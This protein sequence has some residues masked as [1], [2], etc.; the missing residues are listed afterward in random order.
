MHT[1]II[2]TYPTVVM[3]IKAHQ[4]PSK[5][6][7]RNPLGN[8]SVFIHVSYNRNRSMHHSWVQL[9]CLKHLKKKIEFEP[10]IWTKI[11]T[12]WNESKNKQVKIKNFQQLSDGLHPIVLKKTIPLR[13]ENFSPPSLTITPSKKKGTLMDDRSFKLK[14]S[15]VFSKNN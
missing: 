9:T 2:H 5:V 6:P 15:K 14:R 11:S 7:L 12:K 13:E 10:L 8:S 4:N 3:E 1:N